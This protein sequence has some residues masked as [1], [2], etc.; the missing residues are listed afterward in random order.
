MRRST[1]RRTRGPGA[2]R[3][4]AT[5]G[6]SGST[7]AQRVSRLLRRRAH[8]LR[9]LWAAGAAVMKVPT[10]DRIFVLLPKEFLV[11]QDVDVRR[12]LIAVLALKERDRA[13]VLFS[14]ENEFGLALT[15]GD[16]L[17]HRHRR[18]QHDRHHAHRD[19]E[20]GHRIATLVSP[21]VEHHRRA[22]ADGH[23]HDR[24]TRPTRTRLRGPSGLRT[25][26]GVSVRG[27]SCR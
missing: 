15:P 4:A 23:Y 7:A 20:R 13:G 25:R 21:S 12:E 18:A 19:E 24:R 22:L 2:Q 6:R 16:C 11:D 3:R 10:R 8:R 9:E 5:T 26:G 1:T 17:L 14:A 27:R